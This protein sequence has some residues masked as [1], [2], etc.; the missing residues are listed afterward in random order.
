MEKLVNSSEKRLAH[1]LFIA[2]SFWQGEY[3]TKG[4]SQDLVRKP[5][6]DDHQSVASQ[7]LHEPIQE[8]GLHPLQRAVCRST[9]RCSTWFCTTSPHILPLRRVIWLSSRGLYL[10]PSV[11]DGRSVEHVKSRTPGEVRP[12]NL[13]FWVQKVEQS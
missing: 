2:G 6:R 4:G 3:A 7:L 1:V 12:E 11:S 9:V 5:G 13:A 10:V 8:A